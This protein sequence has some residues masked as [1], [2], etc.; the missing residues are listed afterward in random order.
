MS[1]K[2]KAWYESVPLL[3]PGIC[4]AGGIV[5][6]Y[7]LSAP[8]RYVFVATLIFLAASVL[9]CRFNRLQS[10]FVALSCILTGWLLWEI[11]H[12][13]E[14]STLSGK[15]VTMDVVI[16]S[17]PSERE[18]TIVMD[19]LT[20]KS[21]EKLRLTLLK[22]DRSRA[23]LLGDGLQINGDIDSMP[24]TSNYSGKIF[25]GSR[26][27]SRKTVPL[28]GLHRTDRVRLYF[29]QLRHKVLARLR[30]TII[31][32]DEYA[33]LAAL[34]LGDKSA[35]SKAQRE[36]YSIAGM[37]HLLALSGLHLGIIYMFLSLLFHNRRYQVLNEL[38]IVCS[39]WVFVLMVG[40]TSSVLR[41]AIMI[42]IYSFVTLLNRSK[43]PLNTL[44]LTALIIIIASP[45]ALFDI[46]FQLSFTAVLSILLF[47]PLWSPKGKIWRIIW[48]PTIVSIAAQAGTAPL[49]AYYFGRFS[50]WFLLANYV[51]IPLTTILL[52]SMLCM[53]LFSW[54]PMVQ[55]LVAF[56][57]STL[58]SWLNSWTSWI[59][60]LPLSSIDQLHPSKLQVALIYVILGCIYY[61]LSYFKKHHYTRTAYA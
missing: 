10:V 11:Q 58:A 49:V 3:F 48:S 13:S 40:M 8:V 16:V 47:V 23:L 46:G 29:L 14:L 31:D 2:S 26:Y 51:A 53:L 38:L 24:S 1:V 55:S 57:P 20:A 34:T 50:V 61:L 7:Y 5:M 60:G 36:R 21:G 25:A 4:I 15:R 30:S 43:S 19:V 35:I 37:S 54:W 17:E 22:D 59:A 32:D 41:A 52:Y 42:T 44:L 27:W 33:I 39:I 18:K 56:I 12:N 45:S 28:D 6:G 9:T